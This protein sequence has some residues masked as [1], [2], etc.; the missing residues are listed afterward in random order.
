MDLGFDNA[1]CLSLRAHIP[2]P[3]TALRG[4]RFTAGE[5]HMAHILN[6]G[7]GQGIIIP[8]Y[9]AHYSRLVAFHLQM[10]G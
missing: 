9:S 1:R 3:Q 5:K 8:Y 2:S 7:I 4:G 10:V 6:Q